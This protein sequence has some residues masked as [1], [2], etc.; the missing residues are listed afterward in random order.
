MSPL[1]VLCWRELSWEDLSRTLA[2]TERRAE[3]LLD[4]AEDVVREFVEGTHVLQED[5]HFR[6]LIFSTLW[7]MGVALRD[8]ARSAQA[9]IVQWDSVEGDAAART[10]AIENMRRSVRTRGPRNRKVQ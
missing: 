8:S 3:D 5:A 4:V 7:S 2:W 6:A 10:R 9:E 1:K